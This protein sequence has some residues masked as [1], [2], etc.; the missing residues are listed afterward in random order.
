MVRLLPDTGCPLPA[1][2]TADICLST[3]DPRCCFEAMPFNR[4]SPGESDV[5]LDVSYCGVCHSDV[6]T[7]KNDLMHTVYPVCPGHEI[8][9]VVTAVGAK[10][11]KVKIGDHVGVGC[12]VDACL[13]CGPCKRESKLI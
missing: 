1:L 4:H 8:A 12:M 9:G 13:E 3:R 2:P 11:S 5:T 10:V 6:H 7:A